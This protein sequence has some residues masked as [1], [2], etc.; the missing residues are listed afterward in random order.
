MNED[1]KIQYSSKCNKVM[2]NSY[3]KP[4]L[5]YGLETWTAMNKD[6]SRIQTTEMKFTENKKR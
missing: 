4:I 1:G 3:F 6:Q 2:Y 5:T